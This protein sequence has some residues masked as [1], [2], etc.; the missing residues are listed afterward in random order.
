MPVAR[1][2][3]AE[4]QRRC[5][6]RKSQKMCCMRGDVPADVVRA[7]VENRW[8]DLGEAKDPEKLGAALADL[9]DCWMHETL[10]PPKS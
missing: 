2:A 4:R 1:T 8:I 7:L 6:K 9:A 5:R 10:A 3:A